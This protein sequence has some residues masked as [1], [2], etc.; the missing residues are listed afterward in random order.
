MSADLIVERNDLVAIVR[1]EQDEIPRVRLPDESFDRLH[2]QRVRPVRREWVF[3]LEHDHLAVHKARAASAALQ[4][5][6]LSIECRE[7]PDA[8]MLA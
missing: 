4:V 5:H 8:G 3:A 1:T 2:R 7:E 6:S